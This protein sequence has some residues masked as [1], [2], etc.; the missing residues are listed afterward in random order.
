MK[1]NIIITEDGSTTIHIPE[2]NEQYHSTHGAIQEAQH[3]YIQNG[4]Q[5][6]REEN[7]AESISI[8]EIGFGTGLNAFMTLLE[9]EK[10]NLIIK[11][12]GVEAFPVSAEELEQ[13]N[14]VGQLNASDKKFVFNKLH[15]IP[16]EA[17]TKIT[18]N[19]QLIKEQKDFSEINEKE[20]FNIIYFDAFGAELQP[21]LW[22]EEIFKSMYNALK[23]NGVLVTYAAK[24]TVKRA[25]RSV[26]FDLKRLPGPP[27]KRHML[28]ATKQPVIIN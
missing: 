19:F 7:K 10:Q 12:K 24:G 28:R 1:R 11:Y 23:K 22:T 6:Y 20:A 25:L 27:G 15:E 26:G 3:V 21:E 14:Y 4:L 13:L 9:A 17:E 5:H 16:W 2:W 18:N 8:L